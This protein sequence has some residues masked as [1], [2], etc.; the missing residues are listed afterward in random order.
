MKREDSD[1]VLSAELARLALADADIV[2][3]VRNI[4]AMA[5][6]DLSV[7]TFPI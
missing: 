3:S 7:G 2:G 6:A 1:P 4:Q 5:R